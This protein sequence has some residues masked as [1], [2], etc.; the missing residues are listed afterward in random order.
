MISAKNV[1]DDVVCIISMDTTKGSNRIL[2]YAVAIRKSEDSEVVETEAD[3][4]KI[5]TTKRTGERITN[6]KVAPKISRRR[7]AVI[8]PFLSA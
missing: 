7:F 3:A 1:R 5:A 8:G 6:P 2:I 4:T